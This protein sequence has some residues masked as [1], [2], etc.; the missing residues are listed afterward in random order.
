MNIILRCPFCGRVSIIML[1]KLA[2]IVN[3]VAADLCFTW[4]KVL[5]LLKIFFLQLQLFLQ[6]VYISGMF[7]FNISAICSTAF[8]DFNGICSAFKFRNRQLFLS[9]KWL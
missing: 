6:L 7:G 9:T 1:Q 5:C 4:S 2:A 3:E 8:F